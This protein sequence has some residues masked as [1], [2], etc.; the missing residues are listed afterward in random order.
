MTD[1]RTFALTLGPTPSAWDRL[2]MLLSGLCAAHCLLI[3]LLLVAL[4]LWHEVPALHEVWH[5][6]AAVLLV[7]VTLRAARWGIGPHSVRLLRGGLA[8]VWLGVAAHVSLGERAGVGLT[9]VG[10]LLLIAGHGCNLWKSRPRACPDA[11]CR[12]PTRRRAMQ[13][14]SS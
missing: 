11:P 14:E 10:S 6:V 1:P 13:D 3:P 8:L 7:P 4:P 5:P 9:L 2:G 12:P